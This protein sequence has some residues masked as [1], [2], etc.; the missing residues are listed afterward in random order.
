MELNFCNT[1][2]NLLELYSNEEEQK[3]YLGCKACSE[4]KVYDKTQCIYSN[5]STIN[6]SDII[7]KNPY[8]RDDITLP[9]ITANSNIQC[10]N[11]KCKSNIMESIDTD[12][13]YIK[14]DNEVMSYMYICKHCNQKWTNR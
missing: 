7:N 14:Y 8:L 12:V 4:K 6:L 13:N 11:K 2:D 5:E 1:C 3:L 10:P 9:S